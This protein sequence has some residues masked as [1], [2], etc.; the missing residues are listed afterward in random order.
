MPGAR[1]SAT[2][3]RWVLV[4]GL[5][6]LPG[7]GGCASLI[8]NVTSS[9]AADLSSAILDSDDPAVIRDGAPAYL[10]MLDA[11]IG[12]GDASPDL[13][14]ASA[15]LNSAYATAFVTDEERQRNFTAKAFRLA[16]RAACLD[17][18]WTCEAR[19]LPFDAFRQRSAALT[20]RDVPAAYA[21][22]TAWAGWIQARA[23]DW[24]AVADLGRVRPLMERVL[25]LDETYDNA[26]PRLYMGVFDTLLP[27]ALGG[28]PEAGRAHFER[29]LEITD[30]K[31]LLAK[32]FYAENYARL[33]YDKE[34]HDRL[35][36]EV[37]GADPEAPGLTL[38]NAIAQEQA[39][40][41]LESSDGYF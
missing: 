34:L 10:I 2:W 20:M 13:L 5:G 30:G 7:L 11:L 22:A 16:L 29:A 33:V 36:G 37:L 3:R 41:L 4:L 27:E 28:R 12:E 19:T 38:M 14:R 40:G 1:P 32:V 17:L 39:R 35:L 26:G 24:N 25:E 21:L 31:H 9:L 8:A 18:P 6:L 23:D 15:S